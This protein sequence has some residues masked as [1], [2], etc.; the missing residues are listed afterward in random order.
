MGA[1]E[2]GV[3][4]EDGQLLGLV[5]DK[6]RSFRESR[7]PVHRCWPWGVGRS[8]SLEPGIFVVPEGGPHGEEGAGYTLYC[9]DS[10]RAS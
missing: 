6:T 9:F 7:K 10:C 1:R 3:C 2:G 4:S 8:G 5:S